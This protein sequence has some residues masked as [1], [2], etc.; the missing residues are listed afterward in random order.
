MQKSSAKDFGLYYMIGL[1][2]AH[3]RPVIS[4][5]DWSTS[6]IQD[7]T[8]TSLK[9]SLPIVAEF[10]KLTS[11]IIVIDFSDSL[12]T[13]TYKVQS[14][15]QHLF[16]ECSS[17][18]RGKGIGASL[19]CFSPQSPRPPSPCWQIH[20]MLWWLQTLGK[21]SKTKRKKKEF[22]KEGEREREKKE[23]HGKRCQKVCNCMN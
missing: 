6:R 14:C 18:L 7:W 19:A 1:S 8:C 17:N 21:E 4:S 22:Q 15:N 13:C 23:K 10:L 3:L 2:F 20:C 11:S 5:A 16:C 12:Q 9:N